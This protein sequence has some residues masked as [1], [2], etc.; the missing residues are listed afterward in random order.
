M[1]WFG[2]HLHWTAIITFLGGGLAASVGQMM[3]VAYDPWVSEAALYA[4]GLPMSLVVLSVG[5]GWVLR[6]KRRSLWWLPLALFVPFGWVALFTLEN[7]SQV[8][9]L[10][11]LLGDLS[12]TEKG[13]ALASYNKN[14]ASI[15]ERESRILEI[16]SNNPGISVNEVAERTNTDVFDI[17]T[18]VDAGL[19][20]RG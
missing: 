11:T 3:M 12:V 4:A 6:Q 5:W 7:K 13:E 14:P 20:K 18:L 10:S 17:R 1:N 15:D 16:V 19:L 9:E 8:A 2:R